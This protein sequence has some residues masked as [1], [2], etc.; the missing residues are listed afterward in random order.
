MIV[1]IIFLSVFPEQASIKATI[2]FC[3][4]WGLCRGTNNGA[5]VLGEMILQYNKEPSGIGLVTICT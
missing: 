1:G 5:K 2:R 3:M 4:I